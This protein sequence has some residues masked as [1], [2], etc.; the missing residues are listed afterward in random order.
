MHASRYYPQ[1]A[2]HAE[3]YEQALEDRQPCVRR[4]QM[5]RMRPAENYSRLLSGGTE[6]CRPCSQGQSKIA[7]TN[8]F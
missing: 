4:L 7:L 6:N 3:A 2:Q 8:S 5:S 1:S